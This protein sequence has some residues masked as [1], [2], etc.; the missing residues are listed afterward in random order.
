MS[1]TLDH[2]EKEK[3]HHYLQMEIA[4]LRKGHKGKQNCADV[5]L[6][7][8]TQFDLY[9]MLQT[10]KTSQLDTGQMSPS[11]SCWAC[12]VPP[13]NHPTISFDHKK[14][15]HLVLSYPYITGLAMTSSFKIGDTCVLHG[16]KAQPSFNGHKVTLVE[17]MAKEGRFVLKPTEPNASLPPVLA[18]K[19]DN[20]KLAP[21]STSPSQKYAPGTRLILEGLK[22]QPQF[23][24][25]EVTVTGFLFDQGRYKVKPSELKTPLPPTLAIRPE[26]LT[27]IAREAPTRGL[28]RAS[29]QR[30]LG[31]SLLGGF[32]QY[33][34]RNL[35]M[36]HGDMPHQDAS[37][38][39]VE[40]DEKLHKA[41]TEFTLQGLRSVPHFNGHNVIIKCY[42]SDQ[43]RYEVEPA[44]SGGP[45]PA[46]FAVKPDNLVPIR[47]KPQRSS[48]SRSLRSQDMVSNGPKRE[49]KLVKSKSQRSVVR[50]VPSR[51][52][53]Q[54]S[55]VMMEGQGGSSSR[56]NSASGMQSIGQPV[57]DGNMSLK[58]GDK[59]AV[60][61]LQS[62]PH[63][64]GEHVII[65]GFHREQGRYQ[66]SPINLTSSMPQV[67]ALKPDN[68]RLVVKQAV[69]KDSADEHF[70]HVAANPVPTS[71]EVHHSEDA[72]NDQTLDEV[73]SLASTRSYQK[74]YTVGTRVLVQKSN[75]PQLKGHTFQVAEVFT[76][77]RQYKLEAVG[78][79]AMDA[80]L[81]GEVVLG[82]DDL[83]AERS[84]EDEKERLEPGFR[85]VIE[86][87]SASLN[88]H[89]VKVVNYN[90]RRKS[91]LVEP[92]GRLAKNSAGSEG[93]LLSGRNIKAAP[94]TSFWT[95]VSKRGRKM[96]VPCH[97]KVSRTKSGQ[98]SVTAYISSFPGIDKVTALGKILLGEDRCDWNNPDEVVVALTRCG[99]NPITVE[100]KD[101][102]IYQS[103]GE[104]EIVVRPEKHAS[105]ID[106][107]VEFELIVDTGRFVDVEGYGL[108]PV[109]K[110]GFCIDDACKDQSCDLSTG[111]PRSVVSPADTHEMTRT[112]KCSNRNTM[113]NSSTSSIQSDGLFEDDHA[114][115]SEPTMKRYL[116]SRSLRKEG[117]S[118]RLG[119]EMS[120]KKL[121]RGDSS[122][123]LGEKKKSSR[124]L[125]ADS[126]QANQ[127]DETNAPKQSISDIME[128]IAAKEREQKKLEDDLLALKS[129]MAAV[130]TASPAY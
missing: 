73:S 19:P 125:A 52:N 54:R 27:P 21:A 1:L 100:V 46:E 72:E 111:S 28:Q 69:V 82:H 92:L 93:I 22:A 97:V 71:I 121:D 77:K 64:N 42:L 83:V 99:S 96:F 116:S 68:L 94:V 63:W 85:G 4:R 57:V 74:T 66:V 5:Q 49:S 45:L 7:F 18:I 61:G 3:A 86:G 11:D 26:N 60:I 80:C 127:Y 16:L 91:Y 37:T 102:A 41:G 38:H 50:M 107:L 118:R 44:N 24:G 30:G 51:S 101:S 59:V 122:R 81:G 123:N 23:N 67:L 25:H 89:L 126:Q 33:S 58:P 104:N 87:L 47:P 119:N 65:N 103:L 115:E 15:S 130:I 48:S 90:K 105:T 36:S 120:Q 114:A 40:T 109:Y 17:W 34:Q 88:G 113:M 79:E 39:P 13:R 32:R 106:A 6:I 95:T 29:S 75:N 128:A 35:S 9:R 12:F 20:L 112:V 31:S 108:L 55:L 10:P 129:Q 2:G 76:K 117:S 14:T 110:L 62:Q 53:S 70:H 98:N 78:P 84:D 56:R 8:L 43:G 124:K